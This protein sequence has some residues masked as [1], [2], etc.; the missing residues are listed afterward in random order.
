MSDEMTDLL[1]GYQRFKQKYYVESSLYETLVKEGQQPK[2]LVITCCDSRVDPAILLDAKPGELFVVRNVANLVPPCDESPRHHS[3]SAAIE[4]AVL[5]LGVS[6]IILLGHSHCGGIKALMENKSEAHNTAFIGPWMAIAKAAKQNVL[7]QHPQNSLDEQAHY[8]EKESL[9]I[10]LANL[11]S[12]PWIQKRLN[13]N[14]LNL[15]AWHFDLSTGD[16]EIVK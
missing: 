2:I 12:F 4:F 5:T 11:K 9:R 15:H 8:C 7:K 10:S 3:T 13:D 1:K 16:I 14:T 6:D